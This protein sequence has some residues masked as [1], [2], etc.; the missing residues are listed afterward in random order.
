MSS[1][2]KCLF[3]LHLVS[4]CWILTGCRFFSVQPWNVYAILINLRARFLHG[5]SNVFC[6]QVNLFMR[7]RNAGNPTPTTTMMDATQ[8]RG[9]PVKE[10]APQ[11]RMRPLPFLFFLR[12]LKSTN[13]TTQQKKLP[14]KRVVCLTLI[15]CGR[16]SRAKQRTRDPTTDP[17]RFFFYLGF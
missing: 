11:E 16:Y 13:P 14:H 12:P 10:D 15:P 2:L 5:V 9:Q 17:P 4:L 1:S 6:L 3:L 7:L 8:S